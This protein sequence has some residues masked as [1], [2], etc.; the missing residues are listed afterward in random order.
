MLTSIYRLLKSKLVE[1]LLSRFLADEP[2]AWRLFKVLII[3]TII[4]TMTNLRT[5]VRLVGLIVRAAHQ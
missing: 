3:G 2:I 4:I 1:K 5:V